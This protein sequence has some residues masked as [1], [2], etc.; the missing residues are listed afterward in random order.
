LSWRAWQARGATL[1]KR[2]AGPP[3][4]ARRTAASGAY[5]FHGASTPIGICRMPAISRTPPKFRHVSERRRQAVVNSSRNI[6]VKNRCDGPNAA[7]LAA[8]NLTCGRRGRHDRQLGRSCHRRASRRIRCQMRQTMP[9]LGRISN[10]AAL[11]A[12]RWQRSTI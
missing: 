9:L 10:H 2:L 12:S 1:S 7:A 6:V 4:A 11:G 5:S 3:R 8:S